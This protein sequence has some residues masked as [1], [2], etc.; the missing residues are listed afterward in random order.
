[1]DAAVQDLMSGPDLS[2]GPDVP[3][4]EAFDRLAAAEADTLFVIA[5]DGRWLGV[6]TSYELLKAD[7]NGTLPD[8]TV[9][10][11]MHAR[12]STLGPRQS[13]GEAAKLFREAA[14]SI[15]PVLCDGRLIGT[16]ERRTVLRWIARQRGA[17]VTAPKFLQ[18]DASVR[19]DEFAS[20]N[21]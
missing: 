17:A 2:I 7:L 14:L 1:M 21:A 6:L 20:Q 4:V 3:A 13:L 10:Q 12:M 8:A 15:A 5:A 9:G 11:L 19:S 18:R 16:L